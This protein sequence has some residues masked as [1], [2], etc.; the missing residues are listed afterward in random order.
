MQPMASRVPL[1]NS[2]DL[3]DAA[4]AVPFD[5]VYGGQIS[6]AFVIRYDGQVHAYLNRC[7]HLSMEMDQRP[8]HFFDSAG[9]WLVCS[10]HGAFYQPETGQCQAGP[11]RGGIIKIA[12]SE[13]DGVVYWHTSYN[14]KPVDF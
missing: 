9:R 1:C 10:S 11:C 7:A 12:V 4:Q 3:C 6:R 5:V 14:L 8:G 2:V 13:S